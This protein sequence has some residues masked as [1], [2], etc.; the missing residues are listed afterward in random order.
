MEYIEYIMLF[1]C[2]FL[3]PSPF[4]QGEFFVAK[5]NKTGS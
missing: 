5:T 1:Y 3:A 4:N 2:S